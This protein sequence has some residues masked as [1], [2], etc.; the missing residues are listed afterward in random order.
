MYGD[1]PTTMWRNSPFRK[2][3][4]PC[5]CSAFSRDTWRIKVVNRCYIT[6]TPTHEEAMCK[7]GTTN[8][9]PW[10]EVPPHTSQIAIAA[11]DQCGYRLLPYPPHSPDLAPLDYYLFANLKLHVK[12]R[13]YNT[14]YDVMDAVDEFFEGCSADWFKRGLAMLEN[15][16]QACIVA[17]GDY[18][19]K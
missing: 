3:R 2:S 10:S 6:W 18:F 7:M 12:G 16:W 1:V 19:E 8:V 14:D 11:A 9:N 4:S 15:R 5:Y 13:R 17:K